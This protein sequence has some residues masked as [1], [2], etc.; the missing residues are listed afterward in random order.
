MA[1]LNCAIALGRPIIAS[2]CLALLVFRSAASFI[3]DTLFFLFEISNKRSP[4]LVVAH[5]KRT[6]N[7][8]S[9]ISNCPH[10]QADIKARVSKLLGSSLPLLP[11]FLYVCTNNMTFTNLPISVT[12][13]TGATPPSSLPAIHPSSDVLSATPEDR[14]GYARNKT[15]HKKK[16]SADLRADCLQSQRLEA[17]AAAVHDP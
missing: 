13:A 16:S 15:L 4:K 11:P 1:L 7:R 5:N 3:S 14:I 12:S 9:T 17:E 10:C 6:S 8:L 2:N